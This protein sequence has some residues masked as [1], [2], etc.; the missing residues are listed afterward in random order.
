M[1]IGVICFNQPCLMCLVLICDDKKIN[2]LMTALL[3]ATVT[4]SQTGS[5][6]NAR[7]IILCLMVW[8]VIQAL[9]SD[10]PTV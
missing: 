3:Q 2:Q 10:L 1:L 6:L 8:N 5:S 9:Q 4:T 7:R